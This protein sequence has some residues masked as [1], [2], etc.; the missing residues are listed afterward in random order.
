[1]TEQ[2]HNRLHDKNKGQLIWKSPYLWSDSFFQNTNKI[3]S[4]IPALESKKWSTQK[5]KGT[6]L[7]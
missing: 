4:R 6:L 2:L 3:F 1:M 5:D 7:C